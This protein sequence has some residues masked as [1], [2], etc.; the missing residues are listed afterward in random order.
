M[1]ALLEDRRVINHQHSVAAA[2]ELVC[3]N[4][5][6]RFHRSRIPGPGRDKVVQPIV[7]P[8]RKPLGHRLNALALARTDQTR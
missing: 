7:R 4:K 2:H 3:L 8:K 6:F 1:F 5:Q